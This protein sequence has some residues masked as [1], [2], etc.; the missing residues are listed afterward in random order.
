M[1]VS[2]LN[3][4]SHAKL[5]NYNVEKNSLPMEDCDLML[6]SQLQINKGMNL[7]IIY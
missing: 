6:V 7:G 1:L 4:L 5:I 2:L 3:E